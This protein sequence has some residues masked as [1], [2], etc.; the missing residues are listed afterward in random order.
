MKTKD[1][2]KIIKLIKPYCPKEVT[3]EV[4]QILITNQDD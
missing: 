4:L 2:V 1:N 3:E